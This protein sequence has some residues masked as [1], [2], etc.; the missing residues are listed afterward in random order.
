MGQEI[1]HSEFTEADLQA[2][3]QRLQ[4]ETDL[5]RERF[6]QRAFAHSAAMAGFEIEA[7]LV[8]ENF[9]PVDA[10]LEFMERMNHPLTAPELAR[11]NVEF[12]STP[13]ALRGDGLQQA[14]EEIQ[15]LWQQATETAEAMGL[16]CISIGTLPSLKDE[17]LSLERITPWKRYEALNEQVMQQRKYQPLELNLN[18]NNEHIALRHED[19]MLEAA[20]TSLQI[21]RQVAQDEAAAMYNASLIASAYTVAASANSPYLFGVGLWDETRIPVFERAVESGGYEQASKGPIRRVGFGEGFLKQSLMECFEENLAH[22]PILL[23]ID[24]NEAEESLAHLRLHN[25]T[26]WRWN[27]PLIN[28]E[29]DNPHCR[30]E[31]R[32]CAAGPSVSD[33]MAD[34]AFYFGLSQ[35]LAQHTR[36]IIRFAQARNNFYLAS[37]HGLRASLVWNDNHQDNA[38]N[39]ILNHA[40]SLAESGLQQLGMNEVVIERYLSIIEARVSCGQNG[41]EWQRCYVTAHGK[42]WTAMLKRYSGYQQDDLAVHLWDL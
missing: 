15:T 18:G 13:V 41:A 31:H 25:G 12:N 8:D 6:Q 27:R 5:L 22:Y 33:M 38:R 1:G 39:L 10:N 23:P 9:Q 26:I 16:H 19:V 42:K 34:A 24:L 29:A 7:W 17:H 4:R 11:F 14:H 28:N 2:F 36:P 35:S 40:L 37:R 21:H 3:K 32:V 30:I 20:A